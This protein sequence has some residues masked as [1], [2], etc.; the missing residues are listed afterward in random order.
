LRAQ[1][2]VADDDRE[3]R[4]VSRTLRE[5]FLSNVALFESPAAHLLA[6]TEWLAARFGAM[7]AMSVKSRAGSL[8]A[9]IAVS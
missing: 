8:T 7:D 4:A 3:D 6:G 2:P 5:E 9:Q 1:A